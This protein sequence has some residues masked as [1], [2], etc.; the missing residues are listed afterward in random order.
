MGRRWGSGGGPWVSVAAAVWVSTWARWRA[1][2]FVDVR[3]AIRPGGL[4]RGCAG[5][6]GIIAVRWSQWS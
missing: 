6:A 3:L 4:G 1:A 5:V 2:W